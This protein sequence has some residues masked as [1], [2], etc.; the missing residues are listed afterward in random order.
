MG[1]RHAEHVRDGMR[2][3]GEWGD[4]VSS[5]EATRVAADCRQTKKLLSTG[6]ENAEEANMTVHLYIPKITHSFIQTKVWGLAQHPHPPG[7]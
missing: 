6:N 4:T 7:L 1:T 3:G 5:T 2:G